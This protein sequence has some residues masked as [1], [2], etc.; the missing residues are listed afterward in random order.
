ME[1]VDK[2][3]CTG[4]MA[5]V[6]A[7]PRQCIDIV[8]GKLGHLY[9]K[10][11]GEQCIE[12]GKCRRICP[13][14]VPLTFH[15]VSKSYAAWSLDRENHKSSAS[16][17]AAA[18]FY[19]QA[20]HDD[21]WICGVEYRENFHVVHTLTDSMETVSRFKQSKYVYSEMGTVYVEIEKL[22]KRNKKVLFISLPC[23]VAGLLGFLGKHYCNLLTVDIVCHGTP[24]HENLRNHIFNMDKEKKASKLKFRIENEFLFDLSDAAG[25]DIYR[26]IGREDT[27][28]A[29]FLEGL[30]YRDSCYYCSY[31]KPER[32]SDITICDFWGLGLELPFDHPYMGAVSAVLVNTEYG[33]SFV[34]K[35]K[36]R[37]FMEERPVW[38]AVKGNAQLKAPTEIHPK[39]KAFE[40]LYKTHGFE[41]A[42]KRC[43][44]EEI[45]KE[46]RR[47]LKRRLRRMVRGVVGIFIK[48][49]RR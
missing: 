23:K 24:S 48:K 28:L 20:L 4:C 3:N 18:E 27:Y 45:T 42:V 9:P 35:C 8:K 26:R 32:V 47:L 1:L 31:A 19:Y 2:L 14:I 30:N 41:V 13:E 5:C 49:Y 21:F 33:R 43:L 22:L 17:G 36:R 12:C 38:E 40:S 6:S 37:L 16:G 29:A 15:S 39:R 46:S 7:C 11:I 34:E 44:N 25:T 10:I